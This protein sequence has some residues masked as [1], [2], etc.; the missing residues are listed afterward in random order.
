[1]KRRHLSLSKKTVTDWYA[2]FKNELIAEACLD[3]IIHKA[4]RLQLKGESLRKKY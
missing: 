2:L 1:M 3:R 4:T